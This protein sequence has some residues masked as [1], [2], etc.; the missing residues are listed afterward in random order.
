MSYTI[1]ITGKGGTGKTTL[2]GLIIRELVRRGRGPVLAVDADSNTNLHEVLG[3]AKPDTVGDLREALREDDI[4]SGMAKPDYLD[5]K[6]QSAIAE[7]K[8]FDLLAMGR[9]EGPGCYCFA[10]NTIREIIRRIA[11]AYKTLVIDNEAGMEPLSRR[12]VEDV[13]FLLVVSDPTVRGLRTAGRVSEV[14]EELETRIRKRGLVVNRYPVEPDPALTEA[15]GETGLELVGTIPQDEEVRHLDETG[16]PTS[17]LPEESPVAQAVR[18]IV[19][20][21]IES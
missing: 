12:T 4:P 20:R 15:V 16:R 11:G 1:A 8:D 19:D 9:P 18:S 2:A 10:N 13:D 5:L 7:G 17:L 6:I 3:A 21:V 14:V